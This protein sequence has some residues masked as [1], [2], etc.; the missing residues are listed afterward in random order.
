[1]GKLKPASPL[2]AK[3]IPQTTA[4]IPKKEAPAPISTTT[5]ILP[6][7]RVHHPNISGEHTASDPIRK[8]C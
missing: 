3:V 8:Q 4:P 2:K 7:K 5:P 1:M 6:Q